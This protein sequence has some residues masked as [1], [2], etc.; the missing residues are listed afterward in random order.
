MLVLS[1]KAGESL[2][3][4]DTI[5]V[6]VVDISRGRVRLGIEA[7]KDVPIM[8]DEINEWVVPPFG[9]TQSIER[10]NGGVCV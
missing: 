5:K 3:I 9:S 4:N 1:R 8:R 7:P 2:Y 6:T 10:E